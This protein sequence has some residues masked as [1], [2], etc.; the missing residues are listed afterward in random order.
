MGFPALVSFWLVS[1][2]QNPSLYFFNPVPADPALK[3]KNKTNSS[4]ESP[5]LF[6][7]LLLLLQSSLLFHGFSVLAENL[8]KSMA[9]DRQ[10][11]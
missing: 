3:T 6:L 11:R 5:T 1:H 2:S 9:C 10:V 4:A 7:A 8:V